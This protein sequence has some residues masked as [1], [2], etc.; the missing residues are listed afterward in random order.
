M[1]HGD[2]GHLKKRVF[3]QK[4]GGDRGGWMSVHGITGTGRKSSRLADRMPGLSHKRDPH[5]E[6]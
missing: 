1:G 4:D 5:A 2:E 6:F 3:V